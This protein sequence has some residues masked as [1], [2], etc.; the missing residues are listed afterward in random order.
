[1]SGPGEASKVTARR[2][3]AGYLVVGVLTYV[4][5]LGVLLLLRETAGAPLVVATAVGFW[6]SLLF[7]FGANRWVFSRG[8]AGSRAS[9]AARYVVLL[10]VNFGL[11]LAIVSGG[12]AL[13]V[14]VVLSKTV[15]VALIASSNFLLYRRWV[16]A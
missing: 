9:H 6:S 3:V 14:G 11:T 2:H 15:A 4:I 8:E 1:M 13:G 7:N 5:D 10:A 16:F 12:E